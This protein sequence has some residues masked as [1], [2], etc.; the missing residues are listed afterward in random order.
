MTATHRPDVA[1]IDF[2]GVGLLF[3]QVLA[4]ARYRPNSDINVVI[5][6]WTLTRRTGDNSPFLVHVHLISFTGFIIC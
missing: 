5:G 4:N 2:Q 3:T 1:G 6:E